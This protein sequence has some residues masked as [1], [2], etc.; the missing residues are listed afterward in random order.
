MKVQIDTQWKLINEIKE[1][2]VYALKKQKKKTEQ[3]KKLGIKKKLNRKREFKRRKR[4]N[5]SE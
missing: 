3:R 4:L 1:Q 5:R 2:L